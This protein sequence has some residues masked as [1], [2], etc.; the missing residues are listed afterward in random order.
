MEI[1]KEQRSRICDL[2]ESKSSKDRI[3]VG[4][5]LINLFAKQTSL[6]KEEFKQKFHQQFGGSRASLG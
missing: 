3:F 4:I 2:L 1:T 5:E 6:P